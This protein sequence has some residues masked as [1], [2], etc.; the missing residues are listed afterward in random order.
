MLGEY[1]FF[2]TF[3]DLDA[4]P[5]ETIGSVRRTYRLNEEGGDFHSPTL[6]ALHTFFLRSLL[7]FLCKIGLLCHTYLLTIFS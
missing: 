5:V 4:R 3:A 2:V 7:S 6:W 1:L